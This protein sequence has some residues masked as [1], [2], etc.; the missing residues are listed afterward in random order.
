[1]IQN[2]LKNRLEVFVLILITLI[3]SIL[4]P[5]SILLGKYIFC[6]SIASNIQLLYKYRKIGIFV[7][8]L[9]FSFLHIIYIVAYYYFDIPYHYIT[10][11]QTLKNTNTVF[12]IQFVL[13][14][15]IFVGINPNTFSV[16]R[17]KPKNNFIF[18]WAIIILL[19]ILIPV[20]NSGLNA[21]STTS[22]NY[23]IEVKSS[24]WFEYS[25]IFVIIASMFADS[26]LKKRTLLFFAIIYMLMPL[27]YGKRLAFLMMMLTIYNL[28]FHDK[29]K[30]KYIIQFFLFGFVTLRVFAYVR[31]YGINDVNL[32]KLLLSVTDEGVLSNGPGGV[33]VASVTYYDL[34]ERGVFDLWFSL[35][36]FLGMFSAIFLTA[37]NNLPETYI[38]LEALKH[39]NIPGNGGFP[40]VYLYLWGRY[41]GVFIGG[42]FL[43]LLLKKSQKNFYYAIYVIFLLSTFPRW[44]TYNMHILVKM[45]A[46][47]IMLAFLSII[48]TKTKIETN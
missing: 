20:S 16:P 2:L 37:G 28:Y 25:V 14:R 39:E 19:L 17:L 47:L 11:L 18:F 22:G 45:G 26:K 3:Y 1:M 9:L 13:L 36:S 38:N 27:L 23:S 33:L 7:V 42:L 4:D 48:T 43:N 10:E 8:F 15:L 32:Y 44:Y 34:I 24:I 46:W 40:G 29:I 6:L 12:L 41:F 5:S 21:L 31:T 30:T 35:K